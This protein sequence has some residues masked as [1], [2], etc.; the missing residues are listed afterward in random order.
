MAGESHFQ[1][2]VASRV[3]G[4]DDEGGSGLQLRWASV[5]SR[6]QLPNSGVEAWGEFGD[7]GAVVLEDA[8]RDDH[9]VGLEPPVACTDDV[10]LAFL[11]HRVDT[12]PGLNGEGEA[13]G[14]RLDV[15]GHLPRSRKRLARSRK[16]HARQ[17]VEARR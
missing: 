16:P 7:D 9:V 2:D 4:A 3:G 11:L 17:P 12:N 13:L 5:V 10:S 6:V 15:V 8:G 1:G 14:I